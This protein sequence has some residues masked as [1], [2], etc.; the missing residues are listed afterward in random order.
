MARIVEISSQSFPQQL[1]QAQETDGAE[2]L[3]LHG[4]SKPNVFEEEIASLDEKDGDTAG[5]L[6]CWAADTNKHPGVCV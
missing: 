6:L 1:V 3:F 2:K 4:I 5:R